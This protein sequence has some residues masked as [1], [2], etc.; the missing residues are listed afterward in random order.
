[1]RQNCI[2]VLTLISTGGIAIALIGCGGGST[3]EGFGPIPNALTS[4][5]V[6]NAISSSGP[7]GA[8]TPTAPTTAAPTTAPPA[9]GPGTDNFSLVL[10]QSYQSCDS[11]GIWFDSAELIVKHEWGTY[12][13][14]QRGNLLVKKEPYHKG[15]FV[16]NLNAIPDGA[17]I[18]SAILY[19]R[20]NAVEGISND[21]FRSTLSVYGRLNGSLVYLR[22][23]T[24]RDDI[25]GRGYSKAN[26][27][28][29]IDF[30]AYARRL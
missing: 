1:M 10:E 2:K 7:T 5:P 26:P 30:T 16:A 27:V 4:D 14:S 12:R 15:Q 3:T 25:K 17:T 18:Y 11:C 8:T 9:G 6:P 13:S 22:E 24:A 20:L 29:P 28:V 19:M 21:D 23:I